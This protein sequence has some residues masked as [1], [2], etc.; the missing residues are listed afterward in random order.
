MPIPVRVSVAASTVGK[1]PRAAN[2]PGIPNIATFTPERAAARRRSSGGSVGSAARTASTEASSPAAMGL[3]NSPTDR[4]RS[5]IPVGPKKVIR[6][7]VQKVVQRTAASLSCFTREKSGRF[8][9]EFTSLY[10]QQ[11]THCTHQVVS[12]RRDLLLPASRVQKLPKLLQPR[13]RERCRLHGQAGRG[14]SQ[15][16]ALEHPSQDLPCRC[17]AEET[18]GC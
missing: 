8:S 9:H 14:L 1:Y 17:D 2:A 16:A 7:L 11:K 15:E 3:N 10:D 6:A 4:S 12:A 18:V 5:G 13:D